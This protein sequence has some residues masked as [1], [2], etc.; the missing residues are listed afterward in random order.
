MTL[1]TSRRRLSTMSNLKPMAA[2]AKNPMK[3]LMALTDY[4]LLGPMMVQLQNKFLLSLNRLS[5][6]HLQP[7]AKMLPMLERLLLA[8]WLPVMEHLELVAEGLSG[9]I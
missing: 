9:T 5:L 3:N 8:A 6:N 2:M 1:M 4:L 7:L